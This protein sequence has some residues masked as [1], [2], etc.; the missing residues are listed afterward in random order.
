[1]KV[2]KY[3]AYG[4]SNYVVEKVA[5]PSLGKIIKMSAI[6]RFPKLKAESGY[7]MNW[8]IGPVDIKGKGKSYAA[9]EDLRINYL[10]NGIRETRNGKEYIK[11][12]NVKV[13]SQVNG[14]KLRFDNLFNGNKQLE[15]AANELINQN[16]QI[17]IQATQP[18]MEIAFGEIGLKMGNQIFSKIPADL[19]FPD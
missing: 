16:T 11:L 6:I 19:L 5:I 9:F 15:D 4:S 17:V 13:K 2:I 8:K 18:K 10:L 14:L 12:T 3:T 1:M 7:E